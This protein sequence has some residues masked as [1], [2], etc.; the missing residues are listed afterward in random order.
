MESVVDLMK[1]EGISRHVLLAD[2]HTAQGWSFKG[3]R[4]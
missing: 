3:K 4:Q 1:T 2:L